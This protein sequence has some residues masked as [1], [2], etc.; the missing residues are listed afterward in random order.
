MEQ[1]NGRGERQG[2]WAAKNH[3]N[4][5]LNCFYYATERTLDASMYYTVSLKARFIAQIKTT[6]DSSVRS[7]KD[8]EEDVDMGG[9]AAELSGDPIFK[10]KA[11]L[12]KKLGELER[13][14]RSYLQNRYNLE[15]RVK[16]ENKLLEHF[17]GRIAALE[18]AIPL[19]KGIPKDAD[20]DTILKGTVRKIEYSK[21]AD[22]GRAVLEEAEYAKKYS[23]VGRPFELGS[24]WGFRIVGELV[25]AIGGRDVSRYVETPFGEKIGIEKTLPTGEM[26]VAMQV[27]DTILNM[28]I[29]LNRV[30]SALT[31][32]TENITEYKKQLATDNPYGLELERSKA[33][34][35]EINGII[36]ER[37]REETVPRG[38]N[39]IKR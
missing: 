28:P 34:L 19:L 17:A 23:V 8:I 26:A 25:N 38:E 36:K 14:N 27:R 5:T 1:R 33:R 4:N 22:F 29:E 20:G 32:S 9:M 37:N 18:K 13:S 30:Q 7:I 39:Q 6:S 21:L 15:D 31:A 11:T 3:L 10:E 2:N 16:R 24:I 35:E 12:Q